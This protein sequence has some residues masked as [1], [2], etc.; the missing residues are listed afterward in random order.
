STLIIASCQKY[1][2]EEDGKGEGLDA[3]SLLTPASG[4]KLSLNAATPDE[5]VVITWSA[6]RPGLTTAPV[7]TWVAALRTG[8]VDA[9]LLEIPSDNQ[10]KDNRLTLSFK[11][12]DDALKAKGVEDAGTVELIWTVRAENGDTEVRANEINRI[13]ITRFGDGVSPF[14]IYGPVSTTSSIEIDPFSSTDSVKFVWQQAVPGNVSKPVSYTIEFIRPDGSFEAPLLTAPSNKEGA[15]TVKTWSYAEF[16]EALTSLG[17]T[18]LGQATALKWRVVARSG[19]FSLPSLYVNDVVY[20]RE[21]KFYLVGGSTP[22]GW[23]PTRSVRFIQDTRDANYFYAYAYLSTDGFGFKILN[24]QE[25][26]G[27]PL[28]AKDWG[29]KKGEPGKL[30]EQ[31]EDN[32]SVSTSG[33]YRILINMKELTYQIEQSYGR[34]ATV[35]SGTP[36][37]WTPGAAFPGQA[38]GSAVINR[39]VGIVDFSGGG[40]FKLIDFNNWPDGSITG[41]RDYGRKPGTT[42]VLVEQ[43]EENIPAPATA[44][45]YRVAVNA[46]DP[47]NITYLV[48][49]YVPMM[50][51]VGNALADYPQWNPGGSPTMTY[52]GDGKWTLTLSM[53]PGNEFKFLAGA[54]W[55]A[56]DYEDNGGGTIKWEGGDNFKVPGNAGD[57]ARTVTLTLDEYRGTITIN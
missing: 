57:P 19:N 26:P 10:G 51:V 29:M 39:F 43:G 20:L 14:A 27:G 2:F 23:E 11:Q 15:D 37:G 6:A 32:L 1:N 18:D 16:S 35:G 17:F 25:W 55:G 34:L 24:Q 47:K 45:K 54:D 36:A 13:D 41:A 21:L 33:Y 42:N 53:I 8:S 48:E 40:E 5:Q 44:G 7:Y 50:K 12:L 4:A 9:P 56:F 28:N 30:S 22:A 31:D 38:L 3:F 46:T 52:L 49:P